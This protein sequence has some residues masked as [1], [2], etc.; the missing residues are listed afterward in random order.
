LAEEIYIF[1]LNE[2]VSKE[3]VNLF[4]IDIGVREGFKCVMAPKL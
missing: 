3:H 2:T 1:I 4:G